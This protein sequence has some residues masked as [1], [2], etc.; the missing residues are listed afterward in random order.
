MPTIT[1]NIA[2]RGHPIKKENGD[3]GKSRA[4]H[5]WITLPDGTPDGMTKGYAGAGVVDNDG[6]TYKPG[7]SSF[8][9]EVTQA[10]LDGLQDFLKYPEKYGFGPDDYNPLWNSCVDYTWKALE[11]LGLNPKGTEGSLLPFFNHD[12]LVDLIVRLHESWNQAKTPPR[13]DPLAIDMDG[14]GIETTGADGTVLFDHNGDGVKTGTGWVSADDGFIVLDR[15]GNG[16]IDTGAELFGVD[17]VKADGAFA[18]DGFDALSDLDSN[19]DAVFDA[20]DTE[21]ANVKIWQDLDQDG[22]SDTGELTSLTEAGIVSIDL[23]AESGNVNLGNGNVQSAASV[24]LTVDGTEGTT[25]NLDLAHNPF[26][27][28]FTDSIALTEEARGLPESRGSGMV[29]DLREAMSLSSSLAAIVSNYAEQTTYT[30]QRGLLDSLVEA[31]AGTSTLQTSIDVA[32]ENDLALFYTIPGQEPSDFDPAVFRQVPAGSSGGDTTSVLADTSKLA[33]KRALMARQEKI[34]GMIAVLERFNGEQFVTVEA[35]EDE[36]DEDSVV[37][38]AGQRIF[39]IVRSS[40]GSGTSSSR[41]LS[42]N[43]SPKRAFVPLTEQQINLLTRSYELLKDAVYGN[44]VIQTRLADYTDEVSLTFSDD[45]SEIGFDFSDMNDLLETRRGTDS[46]NAFADLIDLVR[47]QGTVL[48]NAGWEGTALLKTWIDEANDA[49]DEAVITALLEEFNVIS[50]N[51]NLNG[52]NADEI[53]FDGNNGSHINGMDGNDIIDAGAGNDRIYGQEGNDLLIGGDGSDTLYGG[54]GNDTLRGGAGSG[55]NL[56]GGA[57]NDTYLFGL[58]DGNT[59]VSNHDTSAGRHDVLRFLEGIAASDITVSRSPNRNH[60]LLTIGSTGEVITVQSYFHHDDTSAS[61]LNAIEFADGTSWDVD[62]VKAMLLQGTD[63][64]DTLIGYASDDVINGGAGNDGIWGGRGTD[65]LS[66]GEGDDR[67]YG[68]DGNDTLNGGDGRDTLSGENGDDTLRGGAGN[69][70]TLDGGAGND[71]YLFGTGDGNTTINNR[72]TAAERTDVLRF[73]EGIAA[74]D[75][76]VSRSPNRNHLLLTIGSTGEVI[77]VSSYF[78]HDDT[79]AS[80]LN[81]IEFADGTSWDVDTVKAMLL[82]GTDG[83]DTLIGYASDDVINGGAGNDG[84]WGGRG[85]DT[86]SGGEGDDRLYGWDGNDILNGGAGR[87]TLS[88]ENGDDTLRGGAG[89]GDTL[90]GGAGNDTY[91]FGTG[92]GNTTVFNYDTGAGRHDVLRFLEGIAASDVTASRSYNNLHLTIGSTGEVITVSSYFRDDGA[93]GYAL[94][95]IEFADGTSWDVDTVKAK[96]LQG[97][98]GN[99]GI[100]GFASDD[101]INGGAGNDSIWGGYG[102]DTLSGGEGDDRLYGGNGNDTLNGGDGRDTLSGENGDDTLRGGAGNGDTLNGGAGND[103]YQFG[104]GDG[105]TTIR[106]HD[107]GTGRHDVLRFLEGIATSDVTASRSYNDLRLT[108][109]SPGEVI[110]VWNYFRDDG[111]GGYALNAIEFA[112]GTSWDVDTVKAKVLQGTDGNDGISGFASDDVINGGAGND[113]I[114]GGYGAD[115]LSGGEGD[116]R[117]YGGNGND[118]LNGGDGR[119]TLYGENGDDTLRGGA[120]SGDNLFGG[121]GNDTYLFGTGDGNTTVS[122]HDTSAGRHDVL[123]FLEGI[124]AS[125][126]TVSRSP[127]RNHLL[128]TIGSTGEVIT[129]QSYFHHDDTSA[130]ALNAIEFADGT[131]W[132]VDTVK[133]MLLQGTD[134][135]D[136]LIGYASDDVINGGAGN[137]SIWGGRGTDT[138][139]GGEG[140]DRLYGWD[141]NDILNGGAGRDTLSGENGDDTLRGGAGNGDSLNGG[142][143]NDTYLFGSGDGNT[144]VSNHDTGA[145]RNDVLRF[146]EGIA[147]S[148]VTASRG[149][150]WG[151]NDL[152]LTIGSPGEVVTVS[153]YFRGDGAGGYALN[154][155]EF[156]DGTSWDVDTVKAMLLQGTDGNDTLIGYASD[157][158]ING[159]DGDDRLYGGNG[160]D[161]LNGGAGRDTL[162]GENGDDTLRGGAGSDSLDGGAG[163]DTYLFGSGDGNTTIR[164]HDTGAGRHDVLRF[165]EGIAASDVTA[166]RSAHHRRRNDLLLTIGAAGEVIT[167]SNY[168]HGDGAGGYALNAIEFADGTNWDVDTVKAKVLESTDGNDS[169]TGFASDDVINGGDGDDRLYGGNGDDTLNGGDGS[170]TLS[171]DNGNDTLNGGDGR[172]TLSGGNGD[173]TLR[174]GAGANDYLDG[175]AGNDTYEFGSGDG[176]TTIRNH[177]TGAGRHDVLRF[178]EG[179]A[180]SDVTASRSAHRRRRNDLML[181]IGAAGEVI[182]VS[183]YFHGDGAGGYALNAIEF[184]DGTSWDVDTVKAKVLESTDGNDFILGFAP[185]EVLNGGAGDDIVGGADGD[186]TVSGDTGDDQLWGDNGNDVLDGG[187][188]SDTLYGGNGNDTLNGGAGRDT[189]SG[190]NG[191]DTLRGGAGSDS[192][193]GGAG[194]DTYQF[195]SGDGNTTIRN[196]DTGAGRHDVLRFLEGIAASDVTASR[197]AHRRRRNDLMLTIGAAGE[198]ITVSNYFHGDG[199][200]GYA[201]DAIEFAD[202]TSWDVDTVKA[203]VLQGTDGNDFIL[204]FAPDE[205][206]NG[207][208]GDD[209]VGGADGDDTVSGD[210]GD[211]QL[212]G[213]NGN[214]VLD[215]GDGSDTLYGGNGND[216]LNGGAGRDTLSGQDGDDTLRGGA[217]SDSL[218]GGAGNDT[219]QFGSGDGNTT[220]AP[221]VK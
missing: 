109:G 86:L 63:G 21:F 9:F 213:D 110:T 99:D 204:G 58:G 101:V 100:S 116:D 52:S 34:T 107:T 178:L 140:D 186:D 165:L 184:A 187:D 183:N 141:G 169:I 48:Y 142:A 37:T 54:A 18:T 1:V 162:S 43:T 192:L 70:D 182:T 112:D 203:K 114:W 119:D 36:E 193:D 6:D 3:P 145:G 22:I 153:N 35:G 215:G 214:D 39:A 64:N 8:E 180:A 111:A 135:N 53:I 105:N 12:E 128:L 89:N 157:D 121:A 4:G 47:Y 195:G 177:D 10:Q 87:D 120:G 156:A 152:R 212:W 45:L 82:Q 26:Y 31:W 210:T 146:L 84:I 171:G 134:G 79:S 206:L 42:S 94:N 66:G 97:T 189:L 103:T 24:H 197:S 38:G 144:T 138:L 98:D 170:D 159:G 113:S 154:A 28:E 202:G 80:A 131:S 199:A 55:D 219:Y 11:L 179:I 96:V 108:I 61:A 14:D 90:N 60:L 124:A 211:D 208:A 123:R 81:A 23:D 190:G 160:D 221:L 13:R 7:Y 29:R 185:D 137:D 126:I 207:G 85:T 17:T 188:G 216:T 104:T 194:N 164:N 151:T 173:D 133:A 191:D 72:D 168:F 78:H 132:D 71:T 147:A 69:G 148:D 150:G 127:N 65:T 49:E 95:A 68:W 143:G 16:T 102:A 93:G 56:F 117:L 155:I 205:V 163:N 20:K 167:V 32:A 75:V 88:G 130:S 172:D 201:L 166:S 176:N 62:T 91:Q 74:S 125:D 30:G 136:T 83:N 115:T 174:G 149:H 2:R 73:L 129:V 50:T 15:N 25:A 76:T 92:D 209:I 158:V 218:D 59:K 67:L 196:H 181:T 175:G 19:G 57:G 51:G 118:T 198:V 122:N 33:E 106:N 77:T 46:V 217:G 220:M 44:L 27:R 5:M 161:T 139:S 41:R 200:G 40:S